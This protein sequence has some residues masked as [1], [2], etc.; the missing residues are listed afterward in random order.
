MTAHNGSRFSA[1]GGI[2]TNGSGAVVLTRELRLRIDPPHRTSLEGLAKL[3]GW[4]SVTEFAEALLADAIERASRNTAQRHFLDIVIAQF[5]CA[6][7]G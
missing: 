6:R 2:K 1:A 7:F 5:A 4:A 3:H